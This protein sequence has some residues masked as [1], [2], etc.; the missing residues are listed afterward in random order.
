[1]IISGDA[2]AKTA[3]HAQDMPGCKAR[4]WLFCCVGKALE[5]SA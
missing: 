4:Q 5:F 2:L 3:R 1:M